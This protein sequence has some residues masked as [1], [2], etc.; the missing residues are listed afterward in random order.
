MKS[1]ILR[2]AIT[3]LMI[4]VPL[5]VGVAHA[6]VTEAAD[7]G[8]NSEEAGE[9]EIIVTGTLITNPGLQTASPVAVIGAEEISFRQ[10]STAEELL[11]D[12]PAVRPALGPGVNNGSDGSATI[13]LRGIGDQ[14]TL[15]L[16]DG[17][18][19]VPFGLDG[20]TDTNVIPIALVE[21]VDVVTGG[22]SSI[23]GA[24]A[25]AGVVN[26]ITKRD[27]SGLELNA[28]Y[29]ISERGDAA[30]FRADALVGANFD[31]DRG[32]VVLG[33]GYTKADPLLHTQRS[34]SQFPIS[35]A[36]GLFA[37]ATAAQVTIFASPTNA[38]LGL[39]ASTFGAV[40]DPATGLLR[41]ATAADTYNT[42]NGTYF[43]TPLDRI[44]AYASG[45]YEVSDGI[46]FYS[47]AM[48]TR[49][50]VRLQLA[51]SGTFGNTYRLSLNNPYLPVGIRNQLC[52]ATDTNTA[53]A[54][55]QPI[56]A[57]NCTAA[58]AVQ[59]GPGTPGYIEIPVVAQRRFT[60]YGPRGN[61]I[62]S[63]MFQVQAGFRGS[64]TEGINYNVSAQY[65][66]TAQTQIRQ[67]WG[68]FSRVQQ[69]LRAYR[70]P[71]GQAVCADT[72][73]SCVPLNLFGPN[74]SISAD[75]LAF[76]DL[77]AI[78]RRKTKLTVVTGNVEGDLFGLT[79]PFGETPVGFAIG[80]EYRK[81]SAGSNP[82]GPSQIQGEVLGT[83]A[84]TPPDRGGYNVKEVF[85]ELI[86]PIVEDKPFFYNLSAEGGIR[87]S[88][89][90]TTGKS[91]TWKAGGSYEPFEGYKFRGMYQIAV[92]SP[93]IQELF[94]SSV[95]GLGNLTV[96]PCQGTITVPGVI[97]LCQQTGAPAGT[98]GSIPAP[99]SGQINVTTQGNRNLDVERART[100][101]L[102]G[103]INPSVLP[104]FS[105][106]VDYFNIRIKQAITQPTQ[107]DILNGCYSVANNP[108]FAFN[109]FCQLIGRNPL[110]GSL[111]GAGETPG[112]ILGFSNLGV[113]KTAGVD[114]GLTQ[115]ISL[116]DAGIAN[117]GNITI[118]MNATWL[119]YYTFQANPNSINRDCTGYYS[120]SGCTNPRSNWRW[121]GRLTYSRDV[122]DVSLLWSHINAV[123]LEP[124]APTPRPP[125]TT[126]QT[127]GPNPAT[128]L[129]AF[130]RIP[131]FDYFDLAARVRPTEE[132]E[133]SLTVDNLFDKKPPLVGSG[134]GGTAFNSGNTFPTLYD[135]IGRS[136]TIG[137]RLKF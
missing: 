104:G 137:A 112:V 91:T 1:Q 7:A 86:V 26:F 95:Q 106:T 71:T 21:R 56:T 129:D 64:V 50:Q 23:Y 96:D 28:N 117:S 84:R 34:I 105:L 93:N 63:Q 15:V 79:S 30:R 33:I 25:V 3:A 110:T 103:I 45:R 101:T 114:F 111:N 29:R 58:A 72:S 88:D 16:L 61:P 49:N 116:A 51:P 67:N 122:F 75:Q 53:V 126:P 124:A 40:V 44:N 66:E 6:Q 85:A 78:I 12:L 20:L 108:T 43:Q 136:F 11:R 125:L 100:Y 109:A 4:S 130:E 10:V 52:N 113:I 69:A 73:N 36:N 134:V 62:E 2:R 48:F 131:S 8:A 107:A 118:G 46:E 135:P 41:A 5:N 37:G 97:P 57:A 24:D 133:L 13:N 14:R 77:D 83:G 76:I 119:D 121:N 19:V 55:I 89:Y 115:R 60:E 59:G 82:D 90:S 38:N 42:N 99:T 132:L 120:P 32:N 18:R 65:G 102:G 35:S 127:G 87:F 94:Q 39:P 17:R 68:S 81:I 9:D 47:T 123:A 80:A 128:V 74:G 22:A 98:I 27:F 92:R 70:T 54:G 31:D